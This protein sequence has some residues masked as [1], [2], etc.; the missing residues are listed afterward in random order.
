V[1]FSI[2]IFYKNSRAVFEMNFHTCRNLYSNQ[3]ELARASAGSPSGC[4]MGDSLRKMKNFIQ[5]KKAC[6]SIRKP[7]IKFKQKKL[8]K[9]HLYF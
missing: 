6:F 5:N 3:A 4:S 8:T 9:K 1:I 7:E 2:A